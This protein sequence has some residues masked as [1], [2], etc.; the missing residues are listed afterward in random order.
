MNFAI[1]FVV[2]IMLGVCN[3]KINAGLN[4]NPGQTNVHINFRNYYILLTYVICV[5]D[6]LPI[7]GK[8]IGDY[9][10]QSM[11]CDINQFCSSSG[12]YGTCKCM[13]NMVYD[14][15]TM[16]CKPLACDPLFRSCPNDMN[17]IQNVCTEYCDLSAS[18]CK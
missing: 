14:T 1:Y 11:D 13:P 9:C 5:G 17:C 16:T 4:F 2:G 3:G 6:T 8:T 15:K 7:K 10:K 18:D 12:S